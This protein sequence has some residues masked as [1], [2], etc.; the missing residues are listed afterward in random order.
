M[1]RVFQVRHEQAPARYQRLENIINRFQQQGYD[2]VAEFLR[3][4]SRRSARTAI[5][6]SYPLDYLNEFIQQKYNGYDIQTILPELKSHDMTH[7]DVYKLLN[8]FVGYLQN[9]TKNG[10]RLAP[11]SLINYIIAARSY[12]QYNDIEISPAKF[13][14]KVSLPVLYN[15]DHDAIDADDI[16]NI[17]HHC[18]NKRLKTYILVLASGGMRAIE[19]LA[20]R[21]CDVDF[22][23]IDF[24]DPNDTAG[25]ATVRIRKEFAKTRTERHIFISNEAA[26]Y[27]HDWLEWKYRDRHSENKKLK[28]K[29]RSS[30]DLIFAKSQTAA[31]GYPQGLYNRIL[32]EFQ[33][34]IQIAGYTTRRE[35]GVYNRRLVSFHSFR[36]FV[37]TA[38]ANRVSTD[39]SEFLLGHK[40]STYYVNKRDELKQIYKEK[41]MRYLT[42]LDY[43]TLDA[44][45]KNFEAQL[46]G[47]V[48][49]KD[50]EIGELKHRI[51]EL[52]SRAL[53]TR[54][55][56]QLERFQQQL[57]ELKQV[58]NNNN[59]NKKEKTTAASS[60][61]RRVNVFHE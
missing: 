34:A 27:L 10:S 56:T 4:K 8:S 40:K 50:N 13:K 9:E 7:F 30:D 41:C 17:L 60:L 44:T 18:D 42:F 16:K 59:N 24:A 3:S 49:Q 38:I 14:H 26:R 1:T 33:K 47:V 37:K 11:K 61:K 12:F 28:N 53:D 54:Q 22:T 19:A 46:K 5:G 21:E 57:D 25:P 36:R 2:V 32:I 29:I 15:E 39:Y 55:L 23:G 52:E 48:E 6:F 58:I 43:P 45:S 31:G 20:M 35:D 51:A